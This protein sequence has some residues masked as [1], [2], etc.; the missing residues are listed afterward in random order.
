MWYKKGF[1][2]F[3]SFLRRCL[4]DEKGTLLCCQEQKQKHETKVASLFVV[5]FFCFSFLTLLSAQAREKTPFVPI[6]SR[7]RIG[8]KHNASKTC[9]V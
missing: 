3:S 7:G 2:L 1:I 8:G 4:D 5:S 6:R 9:F